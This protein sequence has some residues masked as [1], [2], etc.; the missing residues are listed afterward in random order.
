MGKYRI[1]RLL[2]EGNGSLVW[3][4]EHCGLRQK[5]VV[6]RIEKDNPFCYFFFNESKI[7]KNLKYAGIP[8]IFD[9]EE[10][11]K[12]G[13][14]IEEY[15][16][17]N[18]Y[19]NQKLILTTLSLE[20][21]LQDFLQLC[22]LLDYLHQQKP[23]PILYMDLKPEHIIHTHRGIALVD[24]GSAIELKGRPM[25]GTVMGTK[26]F[27]APEAIKGQEID[28]R[29]D[30]YGIGAVL[31]WCLTGSIATE[32]YGQG[33][34]DEKLAEYPVNLKEFIVRCLQENPLN[35]FQSVLEAYGY[36][37]KILKKHKPDV[38]SSYRIAVIGSQ[39]RVGATHLAVA[40]TQYLNKEKRKCLYVEKSDTSFLIQTYHNSK[41]LTEEEGI[42]KKKFFY[43]LPM[44]G[45]TVNT[46]DIDFPIQIEDY[47]Y[48]RKMSREVK[49]SDNWIVVLGTNPWEIQYTKQA[50]RSIEESAGHRK[51]Y[52]VLRPGESACSKEVLRQLQSKKVF[53]M[54]LDQDP[55]YFSTQMN[56]FLQILANDMF[57]RKEGYLYEAYQQIKEHFGYR[58]DNRQ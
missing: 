42:L 58:R 46:D 4:T 20:Q 31:F 29:T 13:Y 49:N 33:A 3:L 56:S 8:V 16:A 38:K 36:L 24:F 30:I 9:Y 40:L 25:Q 35:R 18:S 23:Y 48:V 5:R 10:D 51:V 1:L 50:I 22:K 57:G 53:L 26:E 37:E 21:I 12:Y 28:E 45:N 39:P 27:A 11:E 2:G 6:K 44:Y 54:P 47:G 19:Q 17:G 41:F 52:Y 15:I 55:F 14:L 43:G 7:L 34:I 32:L